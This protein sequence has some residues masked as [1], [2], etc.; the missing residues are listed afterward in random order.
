MGVA[1]RLYRSRDDRMLAGVAA[2]VA[3]ALDADPSIIRIAWALLTIFTGGI[4]LVVY[5]VMAIVVPEDPGEYGHEGPWGRV[6]GPPTTPPPGAS[7]G[8]GPVATPGASPEASPEAAPESTP[9]PGATMPSGPPPTYWA[10]GREARRA[11]RRARRAS[12]QPGRGG[13]VV[14]AILISIGAFFLVREF[15]PWFDW[16]LWWPI[17][18]IGLG[19]LLLVV[20]LTP[21]RSPD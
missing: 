21:G 10:S 6:A 2:G 18:L 13:L 16:N 4:A 1:E 14:G 20:A 9:S 8:A 11:A 17:G 15:V 12:G 19:V 7:P 5:I 3:E